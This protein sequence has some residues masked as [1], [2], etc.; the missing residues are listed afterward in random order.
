MYEKPQEL[1][2]LGPVS[3][4][5]YD[6]CWGTGVAEEN[7]QI[8]GRYCLRM[9]GNGAAV[10][11]RRAFAWILIPETLLRTILLYIARGYSLR[12]TAV[13]AEF[14]QLA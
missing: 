1:K 6:L 13:P 4:G 3:F 2:R 5:L 7:W 12:K 11:R 9:A 10:R 14:S 8:L